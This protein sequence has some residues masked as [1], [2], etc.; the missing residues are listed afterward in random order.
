[1]AIEMNL[2]WTTF[3]PDVKL[4]VAGDVRPVINS[5]ASRMTRIPMATHGF[6]ALSIHGPDEAG[7]GMVWR[8]ITGATTPWENTEV[9]LGPQDQFS[10]PFFVGWDGVP[11]AQGSFSAAGST[12]REL[13][14]RLFE[15]IP[16]QYPPDSTSIILLEITGV[17]KA[18]HIHDRALKKPVHEGNTLI[19]ARPSEYFSF[20]II[21]EDLNRRGRPPEQSV[22]LAIVGA[23]YKP[24]ENSPSLQAFAE[25]VFYEPPR[26]GDVSVA[27]GFSGSPRINDEERKIK[28]HSHMM[29]WREAGIFQKPIETKPDYIL[30][31]DEWSQIASGKLRAFMPSLESI[32]FKSL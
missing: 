26:I 20:R 4:I 24:G 8:G 15:A 1:M 31:L 22:H 19:T 5:H 10:T 27:E 3:P 7:E 30:H 14:E 9:V 12:L 11:A 6:G 29:G 25:T 13:Y 21:Q 17:A 2:E 16:A 32:E 23:G 28:T 18:G